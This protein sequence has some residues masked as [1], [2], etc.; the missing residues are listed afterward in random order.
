MFCPS[1]GNTLGDDAKFCQFCGADV[2]A[3]QTE[4]P[5]LEP[6]P[7]EVKTCP[8]CGFTPEND[9]LF[10]DNCGARLAARRVK[11]ARRCSS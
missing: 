6:P 11:R 9:A 8:Q 1:C 5:V 10:C 4:E 2:T 7:P 3:F